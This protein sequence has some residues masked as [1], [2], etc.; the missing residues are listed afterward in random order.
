MHGHCRL[1]IVSTCAIT[2]S[3]QARLVCGHRAGPEYR[4]DASVKG[5]KRLQYLS[6]RARD[7]RTL[8]AESTRGGG[9]EVIPGRSIHPPLLQ[10]NSIPQ[11]DMLTFMSS[12][13]FWEQ[14]AGEIR[15]NTKNC[16][17]NSPRV[18][19]DSKPWSTALL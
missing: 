19:H 16:K 18:S 13:I 1:H 7:R 14:K 11:A 8:F 5:D 9:G 15:C 4:T 12:I 3:G 6:E 17:V 2:A 10:N